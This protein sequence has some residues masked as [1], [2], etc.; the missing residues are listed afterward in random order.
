MG[1]EGLGLQGRFIGSLGQGVG[2]LHWARLIPLRGEPKQSSCCCCASLGDIVI[3]VL[4]E[5]EKK[6]KKDK[7][8]KV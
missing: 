4:Q 3:C 6:K 7:D 2:G 1:V 8:K 5:K